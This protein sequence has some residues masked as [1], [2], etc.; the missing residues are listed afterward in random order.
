MR[1]LMKKQLRF[2]LLIVSFLF[3]I[4]TALGGLLVYK[5][6]F[7][8]IP[9]LDTQDGLVLGNYLTILFFTIGLIAFTISVI[10]Y[11][12]AH[13][14]TEQ[15]LLVTYIFFGIFLL[16]YTLMLL[17]YGIMVAIDQPKLKR[18]FILT[19]IISLILYSV[20]MATLIPSL[21]VL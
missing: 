21:N 16:P 11:K 8:E 19:G 9:L 5:L 18:T 15:Q 12:R 13:L 1:D 4:A 14:L 7:Q 10:L 6:F 17:I 3:I 2:N 20:A